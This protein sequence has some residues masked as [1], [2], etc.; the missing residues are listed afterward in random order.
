MSERQA[1][2]ETLQTVAVLT[3]DVHG[4]VAAGLKE[5]AGR[6]RGRARKNRARAELLARQGSHYAEG[7]LEAAAVFDHCAA[8][9]EARALHHKQQR[10]R[11]RAGR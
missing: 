2:R 3:G 7:C 6:L 11:E 8:Q 4:W 9:L 1:M 10:A 5:E